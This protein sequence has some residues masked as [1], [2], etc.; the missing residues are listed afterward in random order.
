MSDTS[1]MISYAYNLEDDKKFHSNVPRWETK[2][3]APTSLM[4]SIPTHSYLV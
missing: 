3:Q 4:I 1:E 2:E